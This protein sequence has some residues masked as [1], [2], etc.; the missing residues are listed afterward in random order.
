MKTPRAMAPLPSR[1]IAEWETGMGNRDR[2]IGKLRETGTDLFPPMRDEQC[3][4]FFA[5][6]KIVSPQKGHDLESDGG[7]AFST[8]AIRKVSDR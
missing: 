5:A 3:L 4:Y 7:V 1:G 8:S 2:F 6:C